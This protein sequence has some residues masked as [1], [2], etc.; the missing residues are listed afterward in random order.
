MR[1]PTILLRLVAVLAILAASSPAAAQTMPATGRDLLETMHAAYGSRWFK[2]LT[3]TQTT[4]QKDSTGKEK[5][6]TW[7]E[8]LRFTPERGTQLRIDIGEPSDGNGVVYS[9][10]SLWAF[11]AGKQVAARPGGNLL[12]PLIEGVYMQPVARTARE[13]AP[14]GVDLSR[15]VVNGRWNERPV[16]IAGVAAAGDTTSPQFWVDVQTKAVVRAIFSPV[17]GAPVMDMRLDSLVQTGGGWLATKCEF[18]IAGKLVQVEEY[19][20]W[21]TNVDLSPGLFDPATWSTAPHWARKP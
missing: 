19:H 8:S 5:V 10:D 13:L 1:L 3:F 11:R 17:S 7:Y 14:S 15:A 2:S 9:P 16:W 21:K 4:T 18:W 6:S 12:L 20:D